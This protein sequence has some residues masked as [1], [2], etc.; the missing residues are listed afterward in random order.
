M[1]LRW[2]VRSPAEVGAVVY[3]QDLF[4]RTAWNHMFRSQLVSANACISC[5]LGEISPSHELQ[6]SVISGTNLIL[7]KPRLS[8]FPGQDPLSQA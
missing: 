7:A 2:G 6:S 1:V 8:Q 5:V 4:H 3:A